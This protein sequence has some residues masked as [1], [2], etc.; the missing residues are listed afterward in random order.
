MNDPEDKIFRR[1]CKMINDFVSEVKASP[2]GK[3]VDKLIN[4]D[5]ALEDVIELIHN[6]IGSLDE[7]KN[8]E[9]IIFWDSQI[10]K[11]REDVDDH[12][13]IHVQSFLKD[14]E[15]DRKY[16]ERASQEALALKEVAG[17][18]WKG[19]AKVK[20]YPIACEVSDVE[21][22]D[23]ENLDNVKEPEATSMMVENQNKLDRKLDNN[24]Q[25]VEKIDDDIPEVSEKEIVDNMI[26]K[27]NREAACNDE[28]DL[29]D[30]SDAEASPVN[31]PRL[32][33]LDSNASFAKEMKLNSFL[34]RHLCI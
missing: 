19:F 18:D 10:T 33:Q 30:D 8:K 1:C 6:L 17:L 22:N 7:I 12:I 27:V 21:G 34:M 2:T 5:D 24:S 3:V 14:P 20:G 26:E 32:P 13:E 31:D 29:L 25:V 28:N 16:L 11:L 23:Y 15:K 4:L 9:E